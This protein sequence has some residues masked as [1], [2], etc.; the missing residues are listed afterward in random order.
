MAF[1]FWP[2]SYRSPSG[3]AIMRGCHDD[4]LMVQHPR[5]AAL[6]TPEGL[7]RL[8]GHLRPG[9]VFALW[10]NDPPDQA[11]VAALASVFEKPVAHV[12]TFPDAQG[13]GEASNTVYVGV[14][15]AH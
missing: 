11:F 4:R 5:H 3:G 15:P 8:A 6:Y 9:G 1:R 13:D 10:S 14:T 12:V 7:A 2:E